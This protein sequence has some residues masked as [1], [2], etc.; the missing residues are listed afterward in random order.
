MEQALRYNEGKLK[1]SLIDWKSLEPMVRVLEVGAE[2]YTPYNWQK[3]MPVTQISESLLRH[4]FAFLDG[5]NTDAESKIEHLGHVMS[6][7]MFLI[8]IMREK[9]NYDDRQTKD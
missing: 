8:Y 6:N 1:W 7:A 9:P 5:E 2:K 3:G 4:M